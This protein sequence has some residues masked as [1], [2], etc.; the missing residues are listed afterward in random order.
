MVSDMNNSNESD[1]ILSK[2]Q[3]EEEL[4]NKGKLKIFF[5]MC[6]GVGKTYSMLLEARELAAKGVNLVV[7]YVETHGR[8]E[9]EQLL[10]GLVLVPRK[11]VVYKNS[12]FEEFDIDKILELKPEI[13]IVDELAHS[14]IPGGRHN[15]RYQ[16][17]LE[18]LDNGIN[19]FTTLNVQHIESRTEIV[20]QITGIRINETVPDS[21]IE[22]TED[23]ELIDLPIDEL[24]KRMKEGKVYLPEKVKIASE[25]FFRDGNLISLRELA[26]RLTAEKVETD[27]VN[28]M[29]EKKIIGPW[30]TSNKL[31]VAV[32]PS[33]HSAELIKQTRRMAYILKTSWFAVYVKTSNE[34]SDDTIIQVEKNLRL[35]KELGAE[36]ISTADTDLV[37]GILRI[38]RTNNVSQIIIGKP[39]RNILPKLFNKNKFIDRLIQESDDIDILII[40]SQK[41]E[42]KREKR[43]KK[44]LNNS[45]KIKHFLFAWMIVAL[46][47]FLCFPLSAELGYQSI[48]LIMLLTVL[49][50]PFFYSKNVVITAAILNA[51]IW[52]FFFIP[53]LF[54]FNIY[55]LHDVL[56]LILN[57]AIGL[58]SGFLLN[59]L[60]IQ[61]ELVKAREKNSIA[62]LNF[63]KAIAQSMNKYKVV[64]TTLQHI[65]ENIGY[66][67]VFIDN[68][69]EPLISSGILYYFNEKE[70]SIAK[71]ALNN[72]KTAGKNTDNMPSS[73]GQYFPISTNRNK[74]GVVCIFIANKL[75]IEE[76]NLVNN[77]LSQ[78]ANV[79][80]KEEASE[81]I[82]Q[83]QIEAESKRLYD[84]LMDSI[85]HEFRT[86]ITVISGASSLLFDENIQT[87][88][89]LVKELAN[90]IYFA[91][92]RIDL[93]VE[94]LLD[95][96]RIDSGQI[97]LKKEK[98]SIND[99]ILDVV[100]QLNEKKG[101]RTFNLDLDKNEHQIEI[102]Y[103]FIR[104]AIFNILYN[105][106]IYTPENTTIT[107]KTIMKEKLHLTIEDNG[108]G[109]TEDAI[110]KLFDKF[111]R[112]PGTKPGGSGIG[113]SISKG[114]IL[115]HNGSISVKKNINNGL[116]FEII[117]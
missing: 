101:Q 100:E 44:V 111:Y 81:K 67:A 73:S 62:L 92:N 35:A 91:S 110:D 105:N 66:E 89:S 106:V 31:L 6:A 109:L 56:T 86:P 108:K 95:I 30:K 77:M 16:D 39:K 58:T 72:N 68:K 34:I 63:T 7:G 8:N 71:W 107:I 42:I 114:F 104:Q 43:N 46:V 76:D 79:Y 115:A 22:I 28:Y 98:C 4:K 37:D 25:N 5:G 97:H 61:R 87:N 75:T 57:L 47:A 45:T 112:A 33:P 10:E 99:L 9:T 53:P 94:N 82:T 55:R 11:E 1:F 40:R 27:L 69:F 78:M 49:I 3:A 24:K 74:I 13:V 26:L 12:M 14:N 85:T 70:I 88:K 103:G 80:E 2:I 36:V 93:L 59:K 52:N 41:E 102:D 60:K 50:L 54:T 15:K 113:L 19:V 116:T 20:E 18:I 21:I 23:I 17:V 65:T 117:L 38:A 29:S 48:G 84:T 32:G 83:M 64:E 90:E 51:L 96:N